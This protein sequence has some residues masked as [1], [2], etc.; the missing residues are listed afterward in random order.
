MRGK[1][2]R[3]PARPARRLTNDNICVDCMRH[4]ENMIKRKCVAKWRVY[5]LGRPARKS[6]SKTQG[7]LDQPS[8]NFC[9]TQKVIG[10][11]NVAMLPSVVK[12]QCT[13]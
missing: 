10:D 3:E 12:C 5:V 4:L 11:V 6:D 9:Q 8:L 7:L 13:E 2:Q 1:A